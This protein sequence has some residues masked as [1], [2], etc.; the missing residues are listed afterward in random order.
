MSPAGVDA[1]TAAD[2]QLLLNV[3]TK[4]SQLIILGRASASITIPLGFSHKPIVLLTSQY[5]FAGV[6]GHTKGPGPVR[7]SP[8][9]GAG[10]SNVT[11]TPTL[12]SLSLSSPSTYEVY[13]QSF[14]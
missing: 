11:I 9:P 10:N 1:Y 12:L 14:V 3:T 6:I 5:N 8:L 7:P 2:S 4:V 13:N